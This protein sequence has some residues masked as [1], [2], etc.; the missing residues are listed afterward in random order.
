MSTGSPQS[1]HWVTVVGRRAGAGLVQSR[2]GWTTLVNFY[3]E[4]GKVEESSASMLI[5]IGSAEPT[6]FLPFFYYTSKC[7]H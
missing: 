2:A 6:P 7:K 1:I 4:F 3:F 5:S